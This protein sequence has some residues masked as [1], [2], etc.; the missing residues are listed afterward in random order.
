MRILLV[1]DDE[2]VIQV[3]RKS[4]ENQHYVV[5]VV[6]T[7]EAGWRYGSAF[8][9]GLIMLN[10][11]VPELDGICLCQRL[12]AEGCTTPILLLAAEATSAD[13]IRG[14]DAG[15]DDYVVKPFDI[16][17]LS[18]RIRALLRRG[19]ANAS[20]ILTW[21]KLLLNPSTCEVT[22]SGQPL[23]LTA[24]EYELLELLL[25]DSQHVFSTDEILDSLWS[26][27]EFP[28]EATVRSHI[29][30]LRHKLNA[31]GAPDLIATVHG[32]GYYLRSPAAIEGTV[33]AAEETTEAAPR[34]VNPPPTPPALLLIVNNNPEFTQPMIEQAVKNGIRTAIAPTAA[35]A[36]AWL[37]PT[38]VSTV[39]L[40][41]LRVNSDALNATAPD[42]IAE[43]S[44][45]QSL[46]QM[47]MQHELPTLT[48][49]SQKWTASLPSYSPS[50]RRLDS[51]ASIEQIIITID[52]LL[53]AQ[54]NNCDT[55][56]L[57]YGV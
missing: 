38:V 45:W 40:V 17:E 20:P 8:D 46:L 56:R 48:V 37:K 53:K 3:L 1:E 24:K 54:Q 18:A 36:K 22:Y 49:C 11:V 7:G 55:P 51:S 32:R 13:R 57:G 23:T 12:R 43:L 31:A 50:Q 44:E 19:R 39:N 29:R 47:L 35:A 34:V 26:S 52:E 21:E 41:L 6:R 42:S 10:T 33:A 9:Y 15:A 25:R 28:A 14:L 30:R 5:D 4:L 2:A 27:E 16:A